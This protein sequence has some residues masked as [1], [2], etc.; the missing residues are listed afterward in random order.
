VPTRVLRRSVGFRIEI[1]HV[2]RGQDAGISFGPYPGRYEIY[3]VG[4]IL[5]GSETLPGKP[6]PG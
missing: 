3:P 5:I 6:E 1:G 2:N 4:M